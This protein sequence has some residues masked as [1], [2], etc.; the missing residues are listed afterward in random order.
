MGWEERTKI[1]EEEMSCWIGQA[2]A[3]E[4][5]VGIALTG[6]TLRLWA[7]FCPQGPSEYIYSEQLHHENLGLE[8]WEAMSHKDTTS[9]S[10]NYFLV[11]RSKLFK[12]NSF[13]IQ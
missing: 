3:G 7:G 9:L 2:G 12:Q 5:Q 11:E 8:S 4:E 1:K 6:E 13:I 10:S